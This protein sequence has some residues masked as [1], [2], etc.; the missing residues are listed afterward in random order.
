[1]LKPKKKGKM[2]ESVLQ[3]EMTEQ[4]LRRMK[5][6]SSGIMPLTDP[7]EPLAVK[8]TLTTGL[9][10][11]DRKLAV[12]V[13]GRWGLPVGKIVSVKSKPAIGKS[14]FLLM[15]ALQAYKRGGAVHIVESEHAL[16]MSYAQR[17]CPP[18]KNFFISQP[19]DL[20]GAFNAIEEAVSICSDSRKKTGSTAPFIIIVDSFSGFTTVGEQAGDFSTGGKALGEHARIASMACRKLTGAIDKAKVILILSHQ[21][22][23]KIGTFWGSPDTNIGGDAFNYHDSICIKFYKTA[24]IKDSKKRV[25]GHYG[26]ATTTKNKLIPPFQ[27]ARIKVINGKGF[28]RNFAILDYFIDTKKVIKKGAWFNFRADRSLKWQGVDNFEPF[29]KESKEAR[30]LAKKY[31]KN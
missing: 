18:V 11:L 14:S 24:S 26:M 22:K 6:D 16:D 21:L 19:D 9:P 25:I 31:L 27:N 30:I 23:S 4:L 15:V 1:M 10:N 17:I 13:R 5:K 2:T 20:E 12:S 3:R 8:D 28:V 29:L 7:S